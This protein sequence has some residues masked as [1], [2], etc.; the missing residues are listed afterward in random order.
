MA[1]R[2][3]L[4]KNC[5]CCWSLETGSKIIG[6]VELIG[7]TFIFI[8]GLVNTLKLAK[9][10][11]EIAHKDLILA[12]SVYLDLSS[13]FEIVLAVYL[14]V[15]IFY[16][17]PTYIRVWVLIQCAFLIVSIFS[18]VLFIIFSFTSDAFDDA[19]VPEE[20]ILTIIHA[21]SVLVV[22]SYYISVRGREALYSD[23]V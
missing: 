12:A 13:V 3:P 9:S 17:K 22:H 20:L 14:L 11:G 16:A 2:V 1:S 23:S 8:F 10:P 18:D 7:S 21:Y 4:V 19:H 5:C 6:L 15:G